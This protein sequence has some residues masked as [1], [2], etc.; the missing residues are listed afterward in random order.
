[1][2]IAAPLFFA[3]A[4]ALETSS[5]AKNLLA[6]VGHR[7]VTHMEALV[8]GLADESVQVPGWKFDEDIRAALD[9][10]RQ[11]FVGN[12]QN[13]LKDQHKADQEQLNCDTQT[14]F[15]GC[16][17]S[18]KAS[19]SACR[20]MDTDCDE[21]QIEHETCRGVVYKKYI[22]MAQ[23]CSSLHC[24]ITNW[25]DEPCPF[26][27]CLCP[28]LLWCHKAVEGGAYDGSPECSAHTGSC[29]GTSIEG[30]T[31]GGWLLRMA[32]KF[33]SNHAEW[34]SLY[35]KCKTT[36]HEFL[37]V[38]MDCDVQ[39]RKFEACKCNQNN[40][41]DRACSVEFEQCQAGCWGSY[42]ILIKNKEC[43]E[44]DRKID[45][46]ATKKIE[47]FIDVLLHDYTKKELEE[48][49]GTGDCVNVAREADY[50]H[51]HEICL[52]VDHE[53]E[54]PE[55]KSVSLACPRD[56]TPYASGLQSVDQTVWIAGHGARSHHS[57]YHLGDS[58]FACDA[59]GAEVFTR[60]RGGGVDRPGEERC[61]EHLDIDY[62]V[63]P[64][65][66]CDPDPPPVCDQK[67]HNLHYCKFDDPT[68]I[69]SI[70]DCC[71]YECGETCFPDVPLRSVMTDSGV[72]TLTFNPDGLAVSEHTHAWA[73]N[74]CPCQDCT[75]GTPHY[76]ARPE[77]HQCGN[78]AHTLLVI[79]GA[80][81]VLG[82]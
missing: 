38:D 67:F 7:N 47:C 62:Q 73:Y 71:P 9:T 36:Y 35:G 4:T 59:N 41:K 16:I 5:T 23:S 18:Y 75:H 11:M 21:A 77:R 37:T 51:C 76:P 46:S 3:S 40:C 44:K 17:N 65:C 49:C 52:E 60:H 2:K 53:G 61:T 55:V 22:T 54:W 79:I 12:I 29:K 69:D 66:D 39:Q 25:K 14:C 26:E 20:D 32:G 80:Q 33:R 10:I 74:R 82:R 64:C 56:A 50:K 57:E 6:A 13:T 58:H 1:M 48:K 63:P 72:C 24:F 8:Q 27:E 28:D 15:M 34:S 31:Y 78:G 43:L 19:T 45:W 81:P 70:S 68:D 42:E 30:G